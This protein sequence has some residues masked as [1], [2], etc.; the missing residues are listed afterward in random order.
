[1]QQ[2]GPK[3]GLADLVLR[4][5][6]VAACRPAEGILKKNKKFLSLVMNRVP[7]LRF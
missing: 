6:W 1:L 7:N 3:C 5:S 2:G 4:D